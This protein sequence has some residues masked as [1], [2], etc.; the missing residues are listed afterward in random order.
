MELPHQA[1]KIIER[2][3]LLLLLAALGAGAWVQYHSEPL[4]RLAQHAGEPLEVT[5]L[6]SPAMFVTYIPAT[7]QASVRVLSEKK[8]FK[9]PLERVQKSLEAEQ[10]TPQRPLKYF[11]PAETKRDVFWEDFKKSL[12]RW[13][14]NPLF[15]PRALGAYLSARHNRRTNL[16]A[17]EFALLALELTQLEANDFVVRLP[18]K[19]NK[20]KSA[21]PA[22]ALENTVPDRAP[23]ALQD[24]PIIVEVLNASGQKGLALELTQYLREQNTKG[25]LRVDVLQYDNYP[26]LQETSWIEDYSGRQVQLKQLGSAIGVTDE[27]RAGT[28]PNVICDARII[29]G[30]DFQLPL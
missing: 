30:K 11:E 26:S 21:T 8:H 15:V 4:R 24:R 18:Q 1:R 28:T 22:P 9:D 25:L 27:I 23:L 17:A 29:L 19:Q 20:K 10:I 5:I 6:T 16:S 3:L 7:R 13:R 12:A 2:L 14:Y